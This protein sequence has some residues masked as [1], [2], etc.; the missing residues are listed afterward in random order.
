MSSSDRQFSLDSVTARG[1]TFPYRVTGPERGREVLLLHG[2]PQY[3]L[4]WAA[5]LEELGG[6]GYRTVAPDQRGYAAGS[7][8]EGSALEG[9]ALGGSSLG[10]GNQPEGADAYRMDELVADVIAILD[11]LGWARVDLIGHDWGGAVAW[12]VAGRHPERLRTLTAVSTPHPLAVAKARRSGGPQ[13]KMSSYMDVFRQPGLAEDGLLADNAAA[14][15]ALYDGLPE[16]ETYVERFSDR[17]TL[18]SALNW[19]R[20]MT[21]EDADRVG[22]IDVP[23]LYVWGD[24][25]PAFG[26]EAAEATAEFVDSPYTFAVLEGAGHWLPETR[27]D[28]LNRLLLTHLK[29]YYR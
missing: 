11:R 22:S 20:A 21:R 8:L 4:E 18:T 3:S 16:T 19:Y 29:Q 13:R 14:L 10:R 28:D 12:Q 9:S 25:D 1:L 17:R 26:R 27:A 2:F 6:A 7:A 24:S 15:R 5:Q 23:T